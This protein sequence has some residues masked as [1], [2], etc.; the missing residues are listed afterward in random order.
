MPASAEKQS[1]KFLI[2]S[3]KSIICNLSSE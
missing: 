3:R 1:L 2:L